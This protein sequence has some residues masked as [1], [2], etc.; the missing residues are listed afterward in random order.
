MIFHICFKIIGHWNTWDII[1]HYG[2]Q[3]HNEDF[4]A[5]VSLKEVWFPDDG[6]VNLCF[7]PMV[8]PKP[9]VKSIHE[10]CSKMPVSEKCS[11]Q[12]EV[13]WSHT[14]VS[15]PG[16]RSRFGHTIMSIYD[17]TVSLGTS[18]A[19]YWLCW[20]FKSFSSFSGWLYE[21]LHFPISSACFPDLFL[22]TYPKKVD[23]SIRNLKIP[24][25]Q[26]FQIQIVVRAEAMPHRSA[27]YSHGNLQW[28]SFQKSVDSDLER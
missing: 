1:Q 19:Q 17:K 20:Q 2:T 9:R 4:I 14:P 3:T 24:I 21:V 23:N 16:D 22:N 5:S 25:F 15:D 18:N 26:C 12:K 6:Q 11:L 27:Y 13:S 28:I 10:A 8:T 7:F